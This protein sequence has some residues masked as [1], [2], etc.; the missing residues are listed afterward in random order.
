[1]SRG[2][3]INAEYVLHDDTVRGGS[4]THTR[5]WFLRDELVIGPAT[6]IQA[7]VLRE[8]G[9]IAGLRASAFAQQPWC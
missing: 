9:A 6:T 5:L 4:G 1:M 3:S 2:A 7:R 8:R